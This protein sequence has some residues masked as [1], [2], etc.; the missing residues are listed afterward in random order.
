MKTIRFRVVKVAGEYHVF[1]GVALG[2]YEKIAREVIELGYGGMIVFSTDVNATA[3][4]GIWGK[5][6]G[7][8][9]TIL[10]RWTRYTKVQ[11]VMEGEIEEMNRGRSDPIDTGWSVGNLFRGK[12]Y[13]AK[14][15]KTFDEQSMAIDIRGA[16]MDFVY[17]VGESLA[18]KFNQEAVLVV[19]HETGK[20]HLLMP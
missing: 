10:N 13:S 12:F 2:A 9:K 14:T 5:I 18:K 15:G 4:G 1:D 7:F 20:S 3:G 17:D 16:E 11:N 6:K 19:D 8:A